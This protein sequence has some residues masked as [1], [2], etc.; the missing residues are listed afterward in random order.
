MN[1]LKK[2]RL[3][4]RKFINIMEIEEDIQL[5]LGRIEIRQLKNINSN[6]INDYE[7]KV[8]SQ[9]GE[10]GIIQYLI[11]K[12]EIKN[13]F[14]VEFGVGNYLESNT[15]FLLHNN[16]WSGLV[17]DSSKKN[18]DFIKTSPSA[19]N[20]DLQAKYAF[21]TGE[22]INNLLEQ[23]GVK[24]EIGLLS[25]D[26]DGNDYWV[27]KAINVID[28]QIVVCEYN[29]LFGPDVKVT[30]PYYK[31]F[32]RFKAHY[33]GQYFGAS[34]AALTGLAD[35]KGYCLAGSNVTGSNLFFVKNKYAQNI[36]KINHK[37]AYFKI[38]AKGVFNKRRELDLEKSF[39][40]RIKMMQDLLVYDIENEKNIKIKDLNLV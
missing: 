1:I 25:I 24:G 8:F 39:D 22:N 26:I 10:D 36:K 9:Y 15:K 13:D 19:Y 5:A 2:I 40:D 21:I 16:N 31:N 27:W 6:N 20:Y 32:D 12:V 4:F 3:K 33:S 23:A 37:D 14:F 29:S 17:L 38:K 11:N 28:P 7:F 18:I 30:I 34:I 35:E